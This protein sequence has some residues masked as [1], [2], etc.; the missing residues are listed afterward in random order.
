M[1]ADEEA[2]LRSSGDLT[3]EEI[4]EELEAVRAEVEA[5][6]EFFFEST[7]DPYEFASEVLPAGSQIVAFLAATEREDGSEYRVR[8]AEP[9]ST[10][11]QFPGSPSTVAFAPEVITV[12]QL[13]LGQADNP[14][15]TDI[16]ETVNPS[17][18]LSSAIGPNVQLFDNRGNRLEEPLVVPVTI[19]GR[20]GAD[21]TFFGSEVT[22]EGENIDSNGFPN[23]FGTSAAAPEVAG[24]AALLI[25][26]ANDAGIDLSPAELK[27]I[28][29]STAF[30]PFDDDETFQQLASRLGAGLV[31]ASPASELLAN[32][33]SS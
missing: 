30:S 9:V 10:N 1:L 19:T 2:I 25:Q 6:P 21:T 7:L 8:L 11:L 4:Q 27:D 16:D 23:F 15:T 29:T 13:T 26:Q 31:N 12:G 22:R 18:P 14:E 3:E 5:D 33:L 24:I 17:V 32:R 20:A 28:L